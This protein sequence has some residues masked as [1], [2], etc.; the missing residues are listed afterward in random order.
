MGSKESKEYVQLETWFRGGRIG[1]QQR[2]SPFGKRAARMPDYDI[3]A[4]LVQ[5]A[6]IHSLCGILESF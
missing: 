4:R 6:C 2:K 5:L 3:R 1:V